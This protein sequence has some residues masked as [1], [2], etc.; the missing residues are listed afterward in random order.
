MTTEE[1]RAAL[2]VRE[3]DMKVDE[4]FERVVQTIESGI[5]VAAAVV[6]GVCGGILVLLIYVAF[7]SGFV[8][9]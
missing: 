1:L 5:M 4:A 7:S 3:S 8:R 9:F 6:T 2:R